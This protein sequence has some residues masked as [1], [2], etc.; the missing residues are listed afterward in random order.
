MD[1]F[2]AS[3]RISAVAIAGVTVKRGWK[4]RF[5]GTADMLG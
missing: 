4:E 1:S 3:I 2:A 5:V